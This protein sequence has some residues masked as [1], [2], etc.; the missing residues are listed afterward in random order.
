M[1][2]VAPEPQDGSLGDRPVSKDESCALAVA[3][4]HRALPTD[5]LSTQLLLDSVEVPAVR[6]LT[7]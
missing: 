6:E 3:I 1:G 4:Y 7:V 5:L 2:C